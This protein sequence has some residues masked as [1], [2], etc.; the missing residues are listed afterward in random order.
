MVRKYYCVKHRCINCAKDIAGNLKL[1]LT[2]PMRTYKTI[3]GDLIN[4]VRLDYHRM[5]LR[6]NN[7]LTPIKE[8]LK[9]KFHLTR[10]ACHKNQMQ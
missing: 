3:L 8:K 5:S 4:K 7:Y 9:L 2:T 10:G 1:W 6:I